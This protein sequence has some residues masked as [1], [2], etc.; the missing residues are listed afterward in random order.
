MGLCRPPR[1]LPLATITATLSLDW[2]ARQF[3]RAFTMTGNA[4]TLLEL[5]LPLALAGASL[6][7]SPDATR[8]PTS[9][10][11]MASPAATETV[12]SYGAPPE[13][14]AGGLPP[15]VGTNRQQGYNARR[16]RLL[17]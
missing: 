11:I 3:G 17:G 5:Y 7:G 9:T 12:K 10:A 8:Q 2:V 14:P 15:S 4:L 1:F 13:Q 6:H 16:G